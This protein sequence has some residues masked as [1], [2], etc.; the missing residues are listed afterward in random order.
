[1]PVA[2]KTHLHNVCAKNNYELLIAQEA[3]E[4]AWSDGGG[5]RETCARWVLACADGGTALN[6]RTQKKKKNRFEEPCVQIP[7]STG[8]E[9]S[10]STA[11]THLPFQMKLICTLSVFFSSYSLSSSS[12][13]MRIWRVFGSHSDNSHIFPL[14]PLVL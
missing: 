4:N 6:H 1:M 14:V 7:G 5:A 12:L 8:A 10:I 2:I 13:L 3:A 11:Q 9:A